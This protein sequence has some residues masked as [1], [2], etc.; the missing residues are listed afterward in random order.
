MKQFITSFSI[1]CLMLFNVVQAQPTDKSYRL[2]K[3]ISYIHP[4]ET[5]TYKQERCKL[6]IY[7]PVD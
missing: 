4:S 2:Q 3:N 7:Y 5:D 1:I 6:D